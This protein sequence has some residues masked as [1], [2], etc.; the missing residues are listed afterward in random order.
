MSAYSNEF[1]RLALAPDNERGDALL[2]TSVDLFVSKD[3]HGPAEARLFGELCVNLLPDCT[4]LTRRYAAEKL[5]TR[6]DAPA[7]LIHAL[8]FET[9][10]ISK[11]VILHSDVLT[12]VDLLRL[13]SRGPE[14]A[15]LVARR[16]GITPVL[17]RAIRV[18]GG[19]AMARETEI[20]SQ[21]KKPPAPDTEDTAVRNQTGLGKKTG[22]GRQSGFDRIAA[23]FS[24]LNSAERS[25]AINDARHAFLVDQVQR[26][27]NPFTAKPHSG[28]DEIGA[29]LFKAAGA[30]DRDQLIKLLQGTLS[31]DTDTAR[32]LVTDAGGEPFAIALAALGVE[33]KIAVSLF[34]HVNDA[35]GFSIERIRALSDLYGSLSLGLAARFIDRWRQFG[36][37]HTQQAR[38]VEPTPQRRREPLQI[39]LRAPKA[40][41]SVEKRTLFNARENAKNSGH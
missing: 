39:V 19:A 7:S 16:S 6:P 24:V 14:M 4:A 34:I 38:I 11:P 12:E 15:R 8:A 5:A 1:D 18:N 3:A 35:V 36:H 2:R 37:G 26:K 25:S 10:D 41:A 22:T 23:E 33:E 30:K 9:I 31:L 21:E 17:A 28:R 29:R 13:V 32:W 27:P 40:T 20:E